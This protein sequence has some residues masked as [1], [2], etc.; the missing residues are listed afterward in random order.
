MK[1]KAKPGETPL[2]DLSGLKI[3]IASPTRS[4]IDQFEARNIA[5]AEERYFA[6]RLTP[7]KAPFDL[8]WI[9]K[10]HQEMF[11]DVWGWA[12]TFRTT[13][14]NIGAPKEQIQMQILQVLDDLHSWPGMEM[15]WIE[16]A[17][18]LHH[19][20][21]QIHPFENGNGR[22]GRMVSN[23]WLRR[24][25]Q[26]LVMWPVTTDE[27]SPPRRHYLTALKKADDLDYEDFIELHGKYQDS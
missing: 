23:I 21:V 14:K 16:Q 18:R 22:W 13:D 11:G 19:R 6:R 20:I 8:P 24:N 3:R 12:G 9:R 26:P 1:W 15:A 25:S 2:D 4:Q 7:R 10:L 5:Q 27:E 17:A